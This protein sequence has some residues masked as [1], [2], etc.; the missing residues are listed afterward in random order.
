MTDP[1]THTYGP[2]SVRNTRERSGVH[3][4]HITAPELNLD[5]RATS[6]DGY[7]AA[8]DAWKDVA[9]ALAEKVKT[10]LVTARPEL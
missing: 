10:P 7:H 3:V 9:A 5:I 8:M 1:F 4:C 6:Y 2:F